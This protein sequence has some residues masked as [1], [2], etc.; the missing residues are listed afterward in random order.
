M[1]VTT[2]DLSVLKEIDS[3]GKMKCKII[4]LMEPRLRVV[5]SIKFTH[6]DEM[7]SNGAG[8]SGRESLHW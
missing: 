3:R 7:T 5:E 2:L 8:A 1:A 4:F 6:V